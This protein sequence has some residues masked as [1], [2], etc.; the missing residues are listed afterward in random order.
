VD[1]AATIPESKIAAEDEMYWRAWH[2]LTSGRAYVVQGLGVPMGGTIIRSQPL[3]VAWEAIQ[4]WCDRAG[5]FDPEER[6]FVVYVV[7]KMEEVFLSW[8]LDK[9]K[10][11]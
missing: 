1:D 4:A 5:V 2:Q 10:A 11:V 7:N 3:G 8:W 9:N 6:E